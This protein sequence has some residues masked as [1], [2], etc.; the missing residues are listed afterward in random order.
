MTP[1]ELRSLAARVVVGEATD[2]EIALALGWKER[3]HHGMFQWI[4]PHGRVMGNVRPP[5]YLH[6]LD[7]ADALMAPLRE[8]GWKIDLS[9]R[10]NHYVAAHAYRQ[11]Y[12]DDK[13]HYPVQTTQSLTEAVAR[14]ALALLCLAAEGER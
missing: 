6:S 11:Y 14:V 1:A 5:R 3:V 10:N 4:N 9:L 8:R 13:R 2:K 7:A 12:P